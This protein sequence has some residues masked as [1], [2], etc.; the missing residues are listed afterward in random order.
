MLKLCS[1]PI[2]LLL[3][4]SSLFATGIH[5]DGAKLVC[6][7]I[8]GVD[9][10]LSPGKVVLLGEL[11]GTEQSPAFALNV[12]CHAAAAK[13]PV[14]VGLEHRPAEQQRVDAFLQSDGTEQDLN[15]FMA[16]PQWQ[17]SYQDGRNSQAMLGLYDGLRELK[18]AR[19]TISVVLFDESGAKGGQAREQAMAGHLKRA[20]VAAPEAL[21]IVLTGNMHSRLQVGTP[22]SREHQPMGYLLGKNISAEKIVALDVAHAGGTAWVCLANN[23]GGCDSHELGGRGSDI[24]WQIDLKEILGTDN[25]HGVYQVGK[26]TASLPANRK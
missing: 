15:A 21:T 12:A 26:I 6:N 19:A 18:K 13:L 5:D 8:K 23:Q 10:L 3:A 1:L 16:G 24:P 20:V 14:L 11:H 22:W 17:S 9:R 25:H 4:V 7:P 2:C